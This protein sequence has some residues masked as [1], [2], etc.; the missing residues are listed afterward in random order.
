MN[1]IDQTDQVIDSGFRIAPTHFVIKPTKSKMVETENIVIGKLIF[2]T[3]L[4]VI[5]HQK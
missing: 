4:P 3:F 1:T 5:C 2:G